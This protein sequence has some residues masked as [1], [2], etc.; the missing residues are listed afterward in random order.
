MTFF[1]LSRSSVVE[2]NGTP[3]LCLC[4]VLERVAREHGVAV[5]ETVSL[6]PAVARAEEQLA[7]DEQTV[8]G[9]PDQRLRGP[10]ALGCDPTSS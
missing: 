4:L 3:W 7:R 10:K 2:K 9:I 5:A 8:G 6:S 1:G